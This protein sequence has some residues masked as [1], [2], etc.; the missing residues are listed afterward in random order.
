MNWRGPA[1]RILPFIGALLLSTQVAAGELARSV[2]GRYVLAT[3]SDPRVLAISKAGDA[4]PVAEIPIRI[5]NDRRSR[6]SAAIA[7]PS[8]ES[9]LIALAD[10]AELWEISLSERPP[11][12]GWV[13]DHRDDGP[14]G[15]VPRFPVRRIPL[16]EPLD[17]II[18][19]PQGDHVAGRAASGRSLVA[20]DLYIGRIYAS[21]ALAGPHRL[22]GGRLARRNGK[23]FIVLTTDDGK[24]VGLVA[25]DDWTL[26][27][28][29]ELG[30]DFELI[31]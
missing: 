22:A 31:R 3:E 21:L 11:Y 12:R 8:R 16:T 20:I 30:S 10:I 28:A 27:Y 25:L 6:V 7:V 9:F 2:D 13:H 29:P 15:Q 19:L 26:V 4:G 24:V 17:D 1:Y 14:P 23:D 18:L 5:E